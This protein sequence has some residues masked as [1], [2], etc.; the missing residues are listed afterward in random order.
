MKLS[1]LL[2]NTGLECTLD[3]DTDIKGITDDTRRAGEGYIFACIKG[4]RF[5]GETAAAEML[6]KGCI[7]VICTH[8]LGLGE[9]QII[10]DDT[11]RAYG[12]LCAS[13]HG[14]P[15]KKLKLIGVTGTNGK[16]TTATLIHHIIMHS[17][18]KCGFIGTTAVLCGNEPLERDDRTPTTPAVYELYELFAKMVGAGC[19]YCVM[20]VSSFALDQNRIGPAVFCTSVFTNLTQDHL[21]YHGNMERYFDAKKLLFTDHS[22]YSIINADDEYGRRL[23]SE[24]LADTTYGRDGEC[25]YVSNGFAGGVTTFGYKGSQ[26]FELPMIGEYN[27]SNAA[28]AIAVCEHIGIGTQVIDSALRSFPGVRGRC[29]IIPTDRE[30][31][32]ICD[33]A[34][35]PDALENMLS[36]I[37]EVLTASGS[38]RLVCLF[39][40]GG[41]RDRTKRPKMGAAAAA[42]AD[43]LIVTSDNPR[44]E[45][46]DAIIEDILAGI[47]GD[48]AYEVIPDRREAIYAAV[49]TARK[50]DMI[51]LA[52]K[53]HEDYQILKG[54]VH[55][56]FDEREITADALKAAK[57]FITAGQIADAADGILS[58]DENI[59]VNACDISS[60]TRTIKSGDMFIALKGEN[61]DG[62]DFITAAVEKGAS[63]VIAEHAPE[64]IPAVIVK[65]TSKALLDI[66]GAYRSRY[67][68]PVVGITG[69]VGKTTAKE[70]TAAALS[71]KYNV[72]RTQ[73]NLNNEVGMPFTLLKLDESHTAAVIEM[74]MSHF[75]E[76][77][78]LS[79]ASKPNICIITNI[80]W[81]H[82]ENLGSRE[83]IKK[84]KLEIL[85]G[86]RRN[87]PLIVGGDDMLTPLKAALDRK[88]TVCGLGAD[89]D[90]TAG[91][92][93]SGLDFC[94]FDILKG[95]ESL[96]RLR[97]GCS[98]EHHITD[99][100]IAFAAALEAGCEPAGIIKALT[101][102]APG[103][104]RQHIEKKDGKSFVIDCYNA[105]PASM[106]AALEVLSKIE[107]RKCA[108]LGD[109]LELGST[110]DSLHEQVGEY[111]AGC[112]DVLITSGERAKHIA[113]GFARKKGS[114]ADAHCFDNNKDAIEYLLSELPR[115]D[116]VLFKASRGMHFEEIVRA[117]GIEV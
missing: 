75:G 65:D 108:V 3:G 26:Y 27:I 11:H 53:G 66:A 54:N 55:I 46:P 115:L 44:N 38:G 51:V 62:H 80:G 116:G 86:A 37:K 43:K 71:S 82:A 10:T 88:V 69:S 6:E 36:C 24:G 87:A 4:S 89:T 77:E 18:V 99:A 102:F 41:D 21:D 105:A 111:A 106:R 103:G 14:E 20:E 47:P 8:D 59:T 2:E 64:G 45:E 50:H 13:W 92:I 49:R 104:L 63:A 68:I 117:A 70:M 12:R 52:G 74:G 31:T 78:R 84:A 98:G 113:E 9:R 60:D 95:G 7:A 61:F 100:L 96:G 72:L 91:N 17:G 39:G 40:C 56:H 16:T 93:E 73:G 109:M 48:T 97:L 5:D 15:Q 85:K 22:E 35:S 32:V 79:G 94:E 28:A 25:S 101:G 90:I 19:E 67:D 34:H 29:E 42:Y 114:T 23:I 1:Q 76:I 57:K 112:A 110:S 83:G 107:G 30:F 81:S 33:Y 58:C